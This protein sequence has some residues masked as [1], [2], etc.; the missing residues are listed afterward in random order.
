MQKRNK[1]NVTGSFKGNVPPAPLDY[2]YNDQGQ[3]IGTRQSSHI[4]GD[5]V[6]HPTKSWRKV[7]S[8][9][10]HTLLNNLLQRIGLQSMYN[11]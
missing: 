11:I 2:E 4:R 6:Y 5:G 8:Y 1:H 10:P 7:R 9:V 3:V